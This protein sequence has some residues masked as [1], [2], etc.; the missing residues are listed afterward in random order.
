MRALA[1]KPGNA[2]PDVVPALVMT[3]PRSPLRIV[4]AGTVRAGE[5]VPAP[6]VDAAWKGRPDLLEPCLEEIP[7]GAAAARPLRVALELEFDGAGAVRE[8]TVKGQDW[9]AFAS[10]AARR[11]REGL[12]VPRPTGARKA[13]ARVELMLAPRR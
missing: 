1:G 7:A 4:A 12:R 10:C 11:L 9:P 3:G 6:L 5:G 8:V 2:M 13:T